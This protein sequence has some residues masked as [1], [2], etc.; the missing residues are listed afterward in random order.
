MSKPTSPDQTTP[1][2]CGRSQNLSTPASSAIVAACPQN[3][4][5]Y[6]RSIQFDIND[7]VATTLVT[8]SLL[9][10]EAPVPGWNNIRVFPRVASSVS[11]SYG[12][13]ETFIRV[14]DG[15]TI[16]LRVTVTD[17]NTYVVGALYHGWHFS[18]SLAGDYG[19]A[20]T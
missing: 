8:F 1:P 4:I 3:S 7:V 18:K 15:Q 10:N 16:A 14:P 17:A 11:I 9:F 20:G 19:L 2:T 6:I 12:P 5:G 13:E